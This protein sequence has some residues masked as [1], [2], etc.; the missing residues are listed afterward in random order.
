[1]VGRRQRTAQATIAAVALVISVLAAPVSAEASIQ[2]DQ[3]YFHYLHIAQAQR[4]STGKDVTVAVIDTGVDANH[5]DLKGAVLTGTSLGAAKGKPATQDSDGHGTHM[6]GDIAGQGGGPNHVLGV[7]PGARILPVRLG[8]DKGDVDVS[9]GI[10][11]ATDHGADVIN[12]S[13]GAN[14]TPPVDE[15]QA[16]RYALLH[17][18]V[19]VAGVGN[20]SQ[21]FTQVATPAGI[22][23]VVSVT[24]LDRNGQAWNG[25]VHGR[26]TVL[27]APAVNIIAP[28]INKTGYTDDTGTSDA[29]AIVSGV[30]ALVRAKYPHMDAANVI[31]RLIET[32]DDAG[33]AGHDTAYGFGIV[34]PVKALT[35]NVAP[36]KKSP[37]GM[38][39]AEATGPTDQGTGRQSAEAGGSGSSGGPMVAVL[40]GAGALILAIV[41]LVVGLVINNNR[42]ARSSGMPPPSG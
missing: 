35:A 32:S 34:D 42:R 9:K 13:L 12:I 23:G 21:G 24:G 1:M 27:C 39:S 30:A 18:V 16:V 10:R 2:S 37:I 17:N 40:V 14:A 36:V 38:P 31:N 29:A 8:G 22:A 19:V 33:A 28:G 7:A 5:P 20:V 26:A 15:K 25:S 4:V 11:W 6:A 41:G 3:W